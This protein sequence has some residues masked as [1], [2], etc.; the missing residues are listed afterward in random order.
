MTS[1]QRLVIGEGVSHMDQAGGAARTKA[2]GR[3]ACLRDRSPARIE[4]GE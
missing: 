1:E 4:P 2:L 3:L